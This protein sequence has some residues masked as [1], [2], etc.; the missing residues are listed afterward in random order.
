MLKSFL[1]Y[2]LKYKLSLSLIII[3]SIL[4]AIL[5][6]SFPLVVRYILN[7]ALPANNL[8]AIQTWCGIL[9]LLYLLN[10]GLFYL[11]SFVGSLMSGKIENDM[12]AHLFRHLQR[13]PFTYF[14]NAKTGQLFATLTSDVAEISELAFRAPN[15]LIVCILSMLGTIV[16]LLW[17]NPTLGVLLALLLIFK[18]LH[19]IYINNKL[20]NTFYANRVQYGALAA[21]IEENL[22][23]IRMVKAFAAEKTSFASYLNLAEAY[24]T[25]RQ[26]SFKVRSYFGASINFFSNAANLVILLVGSI[27]ISYQQLTLSDFIAFFLYIGLFM[28]PLMKLTVFVETYQK[29]MAGFQRFYEIMQIPPEK[30]AAPLQEFTLQGDIVFEN[31]SFAYQNSQPVLKN[32]NLTIH[33]GEKCAFVG[34]TGA[35]KTTIANLLL[36]FYQPT[37]GRIFLDGLDLQTYNTEALRRQIGL[38]QQDAFLFSESIAYNIAYGQNAAAATDISTAAQAAAIDEFITSLPQ[39][40]AAPVGEKG[41]KLSGGQKQRIAL[42]RLFLKN[43]PIL[44]LDEAT[45]ALDN[46]TEAEIQEALDQLA[47]KRTT[48]IIAHRLSTIINADKIVVLDQGEIKEIGTHQEL[49]AR[50]GLYKTLYSKEIGK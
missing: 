41:V 39:K 32:I 11:I 28:K 27:L 26:A 37:S 17:L 43:A 19:T 29:G 10:F 35:G 8:P 49:L 16:M 44:I 7:T 42:A 46:K 21:V 25:T 1:Q 34:A 2:Y 47:H 3:G 33:A 4:T 45:S 38:V 30:E 9:A 6:I 22:T 5:E 18:T 50:N 12:R 48:I 36:R 20:K 13:L 15:D 24:L 23:G 31:L 14:D 40:Y